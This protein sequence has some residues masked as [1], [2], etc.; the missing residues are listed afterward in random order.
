MTVYRNQQ[1][2]IPPIWMQKMAWA[3]GKLSD[4]AIRTA[5]PA[6]GLRKLSDGKGLQFWITPRGGRYW[7]YEYR[8][9]GKRK[10]LALGT[11]PEVSVSKTRDKAKQ[12]REH[13]AAGHDPSEAKRQTKMASRLQ[14]ET[15]FA[16]VAAK[17]V[18][19][20]RKDGKGGEQ[21]KSS[22]WH[23]SDKVMGRERKRQGDRETGRWGETTILLVSLSPCL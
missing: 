5:K 10:L 19:K 4:V 21:W 20:K 13:V 23:I 22:K 8:F 18:A 1:K 15:V 14:H 2:L 7:R 12:A 11:Y 6:K 17:L 3:T 9:Q 16:N